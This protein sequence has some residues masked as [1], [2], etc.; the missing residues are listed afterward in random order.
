[1]A[2]SSTEKCS[3]MVNTQDADYEF[4]YKEYF[5]INK[6]GRGERSLYPVI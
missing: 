2:S 1:M 4:I 5:F 6:A 3:N